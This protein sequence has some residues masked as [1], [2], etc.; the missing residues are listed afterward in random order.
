MLNENLRSL[1]SERKLRQIDL[2]NTLGV[3][4]TTYTQYETGKSEPDL[5]TLVKLAEFFN[6][7]VDYLLGLTNIRNP[8]GMINNSSCHEFIEWEW[9][10]E[11][12]KEIELFKEFIKMKREKSKQ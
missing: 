7:S 11:E 4:R 9:T 3:S 6:V 10:D 1:R 8:S 5:S 12:K 2:A